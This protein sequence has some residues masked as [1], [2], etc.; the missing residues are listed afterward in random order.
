MVDRNRGREKERKKKN[1][2]KKEKTNK[3]TNKA[4]KT[5]RKQLKS[6]LTWLS[7]GWSLF[8]F[9]LLCHLKITRTAMM[10]RSKPTPTEDQIILDRLIEVGVPSAEENVLGINVNA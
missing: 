8:L 2:N 1:I 3:Q 9:F 10:I 4:T 7:T 6:L 5:K